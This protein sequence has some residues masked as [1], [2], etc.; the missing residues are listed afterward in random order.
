MSFWQ[1]SNDECA[2]NTNC[3]NR[4]LNSPIP[5][6]VGGGLSTALPLSPGLALGFEVALALLLEPVAALSSGLARLE[7]FIDRDVVGKSVSTADGG[8]D[9]STRLMTGAD[10]VEGAGV[11]GRVAFGVR[12]AVDWLLRLLTGWVLTGGASSS[13]IGAG[14]WR[15][16][17]R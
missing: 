6:A 5:S 11:V 4:L 1:S 17:T 15:G 8:S 9:S 13:D 14:I 7:G 12:A 2:Y 3:S 10:D 16:L